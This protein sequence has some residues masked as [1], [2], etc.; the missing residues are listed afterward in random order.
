MKLEDDIEETA[1]RVCAEI[2]SAVE[3]YVNVSGA[4]DLPEHFVQSYVF[5]NLGDVLTM[6]L[7]TNSSKLWEWNGRLRRVFTIDRHD[8][9]FYR[10]HRL[11]R[12]EILP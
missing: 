11:G 5:A 3:K 10:P 6:T 12:F 1:R 9:E 4:S 8:F 7:E 2:A